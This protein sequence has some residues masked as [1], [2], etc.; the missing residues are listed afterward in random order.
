MPRTSAADPCGSTSMTLGPRG[1]PDSV[2]R[3]TPE[4]SIER[5]G[6]YRETD[7]GD[8]LSLT[9]CIADMRLR[10][11]DAI[12]RRIDVAVAGVSLPSRRHRLRMERR[13][14]GQH[15]TEPLPTL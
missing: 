4:H 3:E 10:P 6:Q 15:H 7:L 9:H 14:L 2:A 5:C 12:T 13:F 1:N 8:L 11:E